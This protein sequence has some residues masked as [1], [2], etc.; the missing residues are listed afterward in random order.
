MT[1]A[2][3]MYGRCRTGKRWF[4]FAADM[5]YYYD[6]GGSREYGRTDTED[7]ALAAARDAV[8]RIADGRAYHAHYSAGTASRALKELNAEKRAA[9]TSDD[10]GTGTVE[11][12]YVPCRFVSEAS[13]EPTERWIVEVPIVKKTAKRIYYDKATLDNRRYD[14]DPVTLGFI[15]RAAFERD[16]KA[17][18]PGARWW[19]HGARFYATREAAELALYG[20]PKPQPAPADL[21][22]LRQAMADAHP[23]RGGTRAEFMAARQQ[24][25]RAKAGA[26]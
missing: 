4:W 7:E 20:D 17:W 2:L 10:T 15:D 11:H 9:K 3:I 14:G 23:D 6:R 5:D 22:A 19:S 24:Y 16:G 25:I 13:Y 1:A 21:S 12:M 8:D 18:I 26:A